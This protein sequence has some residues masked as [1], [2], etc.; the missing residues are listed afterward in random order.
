MGDSSSATFFRSRNVDR[1]QYKVGAILAEQPPPQPLSAVVFHYNHGRGVRH[2]IADQVGAAFPN[3]RQ[4]VILGLHGGATPGHIDGQD[5]ADAATWVTQLEQAI[6]QNG[7]CLQ[8]GG[9]PSFFP[10]DQVDIER[11]FGTRGAARLRR[12]KTRLDPDDLFC[13]ALPGLSAA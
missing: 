2:G 6:D 10:P 9:F 7:L 4:H 1:I 3:R 5:L 12:L 8:G 11:F 13:Q